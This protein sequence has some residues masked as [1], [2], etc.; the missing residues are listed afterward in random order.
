[1]AS[2]REPGAGEVNK[3]LDSF[4]VLD[5]NRITMHTCAASNRE[6]STSL[7]GNLARLQV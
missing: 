3:D 6:N 4:A 5:D 2:N 7:A 1:V